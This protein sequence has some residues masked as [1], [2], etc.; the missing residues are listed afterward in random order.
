MESIKNIWE[1]ILKIRKKI[2]TLWLLVEIYVFYIV[3]PREF[4][5]I[6]K[7]LDGN[8]HINVNTEGKIPRLPPDKEQQ[9]T[10]DQFLNSLLI[11]NITIPFPFILPPSKPSL[12]PSH[13]TLP[14]L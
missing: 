9:T 1:I 11:K 13:P 5:L 4:F 12:V 8:V 14:Y 6:Q 10:D 3:N 7:K 2:E